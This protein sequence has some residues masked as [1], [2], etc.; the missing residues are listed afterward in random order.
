MT[1]LTN[2]IGLVGHPYAPIGMGEHV[3][4]SYRALRSVGLRTTIVDIYKAAVPDAQEH[5]EFGSSDAIP[6]FDINVFHINADEVRQAMAHLT[7]H[8]PWAGYNI[9]YPAWELSRYPKEWATEL[10]K[11]DEIWAPSQFIRDS[12]G[13]VCQRSVVHMPLACE[14]ILSS[15]LSRR[16]FDIPESDYVFLFFFDVRS[17]P[18]RKNPQAVIQAFRKLL[19]LKPYSRARLVMKVN[20]AEL[21]PALMEKLRESVADLSHAITFLGHLMS[22][23]ETKNLVRCCD[24]FVS[25]HRSE[26]FGR[27][28]AEAMFLGKPVIATGYSGNMDFMSSETAFLVPYELIPV[29]ADSYPH[30]QDQAWA[31]PDTNVATG[32][33]VKLLEDPS[34]GRVLGERAS[35][36]IRTKFGYRTT[37]IR[38]RDQLEK[39]ADLLSRKQDTEQPQRM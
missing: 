31:D 36:H 29:P 13:A 7:Y 14:V 22:D 38:Y 26:G 23:N 34:A 10:D 28:M 35:R 33:M 8:R 3:R 16:Y 24:C 15:F 1:S 17:Y 37:G 2:K 6:P 27:G 20:G 39:I 32:Y 9:I 21:V 5:A 11:F 25:L 30:W 12:V 18:E 4:C 19:S